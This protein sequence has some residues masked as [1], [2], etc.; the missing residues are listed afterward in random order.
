[1]PARLCGRP[2][3][4]ATS[5]KP[6][7]VTFRGAVSTLPECTNSLEL[8]VDVFAVP[9][10]VGVT[11]TLVVSY[12]TV[13]LHPNRFPG[14]TQLIVTG[15]PPAVTVRSVS[16]GRACV[17]VGGGGAVPVGV[18]ERCTQALEPPA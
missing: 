3:A 13:A 9:L 11:L 1:M 6:P 10:Q 14:W 15:L 8:T 7:D 2:L 18:P 17:V 16:T 5:T 4:R 12:G